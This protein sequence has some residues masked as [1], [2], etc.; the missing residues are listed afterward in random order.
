MKTLGD[1]IVAIVK[2]YVGAQLTILSTRLDE[3]ATKFAEAPK[4]KDG[5]PG[6]DGTDGRDALNLHV[7]RGID[8]ARKYRKGEYASH[9]GGLWMSVKSTDGMEGW[10]CIV[11]GVAD[12]LIE[13]QDDRTFAV[14]VFKSGGDVVLKSFSLPVMIYKDL[15]RDGN[16]YKAGDVVTWAGHMWICKKETD[17][18]P[19]EG[20]AWRIAVKRG[21][22]AKAVH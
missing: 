2:E 20:E 22:D 12:V 17:A 3:M 13:Q 15:F 5:E 6:K 16:I 9:N 11:D 10:D 1:S 21:Q 7:M 19:V 8:E 18:K 4:P 14:K